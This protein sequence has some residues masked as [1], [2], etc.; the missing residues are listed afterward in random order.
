MPR[1]SCYRILLAVLAPLAITLLPRPATAQRATFGAYVGGFFPTQTVY[2]TSQ[3]GLS[4]ASSLKS[5][6]VV[7]GSFDLELWH[8][9]GL[10]LVGSHAATR[11]GGGFSTFG[12]SFSTDAPA[13]S[14]ALALRLSAFLPFRPRLSF[15]GGIGPVLVWQKHR[16]IPNDGEYRSWRSEGLAVGG[17]LRYRVSRIVV[18]DTSLEGYIYNGD[19]PVIPG[20]SADRQVDLYLTTGFHLDLTQ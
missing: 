19:Y 17:T 8:H 9:L 20:Y 16:H 4:A 12:G 13:Q 3:S 5:A 7:Q 18:W 2:S 1:H 15:I 6:A 10:V 11:F 14:N